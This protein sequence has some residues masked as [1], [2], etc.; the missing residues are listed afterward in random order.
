MIIPYIL[1]IE[2]NYYVLIQLSLLTRVS[3]VSQMI[4]RVS[5]G[6]MIVV[7][8]HPQ[9]W[10]CACVYFL[11]SASLSYRILPYNNNFSGVRITKL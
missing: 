2:V 9:T 1:C 4:T 5:T 11:V 6:Q 10:T 7:V 3:T 8:A